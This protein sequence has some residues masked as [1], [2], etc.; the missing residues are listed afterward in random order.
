MA[1][2]TMPTTLNGYPV[3]AWTNFGDHALV[4]VHRENHP[5]HPWV[6]AQWSPDLGSTW[7]SGNYFASW[8]EADAWRGEKIA[9]HYGTN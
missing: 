1:T 3:K 9:R 8:E 6:G 5:M 7:T 2:L 4:L